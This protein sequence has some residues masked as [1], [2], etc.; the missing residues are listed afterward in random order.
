M[1]KN[2]LTS[3]MTGL[4]GLSGAFGPEGP[5][6]STNSLLTED[7]QPILEEDGESLLVES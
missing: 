5:I 7:L 2:A 1:D 6:D 3:G 4:T